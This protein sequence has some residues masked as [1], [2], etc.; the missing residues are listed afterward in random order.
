MNLRLEIP[1]NENF[2]EPT[3][4][5]IMKGGLG[6]EIGDG[7]IFVLYLFDC[8]RVRTGKRSGEAIG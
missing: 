3:I 7:K 5:A 8:I 2:V 4:N 1:A 6:G